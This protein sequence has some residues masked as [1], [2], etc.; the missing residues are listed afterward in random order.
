MQKSNA[1]R[2]GIV[3]Q[4][5]VVLR[6]GV[7]LEGGFNAPEAVLEKREI[8]KKAKEEEEEEKGEKEEAKRK[9]GEK[10][11][12]ED[13]D[14]HPNGKPE[15][16]TESISDDEAEDLVAK[17]DDDCIPESISNDDSMEV[18]GTEP[19]ESGERKIPI[20]GL[21]NEGIND[22]FFN[23]AFQCLV[24]TRPFAE[25]VLNQPVEW[26]EEETRN[27]GNTYN[28]FVGVR[29]LMDLM[30]DPNGNSFSISEAKKALMRNLKDSETLMP[31]YVMGQQADAFDCFNAMLDGMHESFP[32]EKTIISE[33]FEYELC[34]ETSC[35]KCKKVIKTVKSKSMALNLLCEKEITSLE[36]QLDGFFGVI[37][38]TTCNTCNEEEMITTNNIVKEPEVLQIV[39][40]R[41]AVLNRAVTK[42]DH[43]VTLPLSL[44]I[45]DYLSPSGSQALYNLY[46][47][48]VHE[49]ADNSGHYYAYVKS[50]HGIW[51][52][53]NDNRVEKLENANE[54]K[55]AQ[56]Y[57]LLY[58]KVDSVDQ[59]AGADTMDD[60]IEV[61][62]EGLDIVHSMEE[63][64]DDEQEV[65]EEMALLSNA[66]ATTEDYI[67]PFGASKTLNM[68]CREGDKRIKPRKKEKD[69]FT[70]AQ[71]KKVHDT[72]QRWIKFCD[73]ADNESTK[74]Q[75]GLNEF[76]ILV[77]NEKLEEILEGH[78]TCAVVEGCRTG[79]TRI[80]L[81]LTCLLYP[82]IKENEKEKSTS[83]EQKSTPSEQIVFVTSI[84]AD[85]LVEE[86]GGF[87]AAFAMGTESR[88]IETS[89]VK[90]ASVR[91]F[92]EDNQKL[93]GYSMVVID[94]VHEMYSGNQNAD[95]DDCDT[96]YFSITARLTGTVKLVLTGTAIVRGIR[97]VFFSARC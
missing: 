96:S 61:P 35:Q 18:D 6:T 53:I 97:D 13:S 81:T 68:V 20:V 49:G 10:K 51:H 57:V 3:L 1:P 17:D 62:I 85:A 67:R 83:S 14:V 44:D 63:D 26:R 74:R 78:A 25:R 48:V 16:G 76:Q 45:G 32:T 12:E 4:D 91:D 59:N 36:D 84:T 73:S 58:E 75:Y 60:S 29:N 7:V 37:K 89:C 86:A 8:E 42:L 90:F 71:K 47:V 70:D 93:N 2:D 5:G 87:F 54:V 95:C 64:V 31:D 19:V 43:D 56:A 50:E 33:I 94:E 82:L 79:K 72:L 34:E 11:D 27:D 41:M 23:A 24:H 39:L 46:A 92:K 40:N 69:C 28:W 65:I 9:E 22:C 88:P 15:S 38:R 30:C 66:G 52:R 77:V 55:K 80:A 21:K